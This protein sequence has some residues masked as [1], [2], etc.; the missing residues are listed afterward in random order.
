MLGITPNEFLRNV[1]LKHAAHLLTRSEY[2][3]SQVSLMV[4]FLTPRYFGQCFKKMFGVLPSE[5][6]GRISE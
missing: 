4:G 3:V 6:G 2:S 1:R 5:Y